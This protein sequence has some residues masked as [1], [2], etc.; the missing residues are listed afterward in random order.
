MDP[1]TSATLVT[2]HG[3]VGNADQGRRRQVTIIER[4]VWD[5]LMRQL[6]GAVPPSARR[7][8]LMISGLSLAGERNRVL[9]VGECRIRLL[10]ETR[11]CERMDEALPGLR[12]AMKV[13]W[14]GGSFGE[15]LDDGHVA[16]GAE[17]GW[18][19]N[20]NGRLG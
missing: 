5:R 7:A 9:R 4:E 8:N 18:D 11:P 6:G 17:V 15:V 14:G 13:G 19:E 10:G 2:G 12:E 1:V 20:D 3:L 16:L